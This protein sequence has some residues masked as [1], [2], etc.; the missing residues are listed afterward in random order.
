MARV[1]SM[2]RKAALNSIGDRLFTIFEGKLFHT[3]TTRLQKWFLAMSSLNERVFESM[4]SGGN[5]IMSGIEH[6][7]KITVF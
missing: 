1:K 5:W 3:G 7:E 4:S 2:F 6:S